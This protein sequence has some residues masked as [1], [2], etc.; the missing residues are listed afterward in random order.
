MT[1]QQR[2]QAVSLEHAASTASDL[3]AN[4]D[5]PS[6]MAAFASYRPLPMRSH[7]IHDLP[8]GY[9]SPSFRQPHN[10]LSMMGP[11]VGTRTG[12]DNQP[13]QPYHFRRASF[14]SHGETSYD[15]HF[16]WYPP[17]E[18][19]D[20]Y[21][22]GRPPVTLLPPPPAGPGVLPS[23]DT[24]N[25][26]QTAQKRL[27]PKGHPALEQPSLPTPGS[28]ESSP[29]AASPRE[30]ASEDHAPKFQ[31]IAASTHV[32]SGEREYFHWPQI[33]LENQASM[34]SDQGPARVETHNVRELRW[35]SDTSFDANK[36]IPPV[37]QESHT[38]ATD[39]WMG[40]MSSIAARQIIPGMSHSGDQDSDESGDLAH[41]FG[42]HQQSKEA[43][44]ELRRDIVYRKSSL[45][46]LDRDLKSAE[47]LRRR[48]ERRKQVHNTSERK[49]REQLNRGFLDLCEIVPGLDISTHTRKEILFRTADWLEKF[50]QDNSC[51]K[52]QLDRLRN[53]V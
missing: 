53:A 18:N 41:D 47:K 15:P 30:K 20:P 38:V 3:T 25:Q 13:G 42:D 16:T 12:H 40:W 34:R 45:L 2:F 35:G 28:S 17:N 14:Q 26:Q 36:F 50:L 11:P 21:F 1:E 7:N 9:F 31:K 22:A 39:K 51:L 37:Q 10:M 43:G 27:L 23:N 33:C 49:R 8:D 44:E 24:Q 4:S 5:T 48:A 19:F 32:E 52:D 46:P 29:S 6:N